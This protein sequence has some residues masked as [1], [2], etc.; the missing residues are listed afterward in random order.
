M[1]DWFD[2]RFDIDRILQQGLDWHISV[3][4]A[5]SAPVPTAWRSR[6]DEFLKKIGYR[7]VM[8]ELTHPAEVRAG[9]ALVL[10]SQWENVGVA[11]VYR[12]W[13][14][15]YRLRNESEQVVA[16]W[17]SKADLKQWL[18][19]ERYQVEDASDIP[20]HLPAGVYQVDVA[21]LDEHGRSALVDLAIAGRRADR[22]Y[23]ISRVTIR[24]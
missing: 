12:P 1:Q 24:E 3:L 4:N 23:P 14:L 7:L 5:K 13:P 8:R 10:Q 11:P 6:V 22:W 18:P 9:A 2:K 20:E 17:T 19:G 15:A 16:Q 21:V